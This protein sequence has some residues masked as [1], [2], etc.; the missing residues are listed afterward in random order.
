MCGQ[1][2]GLRM[3]C[4]L[5]RVV[6]GL[7]FMCADKSYWKEA[8]KQSVNEAGQFIFM[9]VSA[10]IVSLTGETKPMQARIHFSI[11]SSVLHWLGLACKTTLFV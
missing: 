10:L 2:A 11:R 7:L 5:V 9:L 3:H 1:K 8:A 6:N 4:H